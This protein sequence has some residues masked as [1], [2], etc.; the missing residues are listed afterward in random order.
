[1]TSP[2]QH[3][4]RENSV[5]VG[6]SSI[7]EAPRRKNIRVSYTGKEEDDEDKSEDTPWTNFRQLRS[8]REEK[9]YSMIT[10]SRSNRIMKRRRILPK[11]TTEPDVRVNVV[12]KKLR[13]RQSPKEQH[14][15]SNSPHLASRHRLSLNRNNTGSNA[16]GKKKELR[17]TKSSSDNELNILTLDDGS[18][19]TVSSLPLAM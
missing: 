13:V 18:F 15:P 16:C 6:I 10:P 4:G 5:K 1:M 3:R 14:V 11:N 2:L 8:Q 7:D 17:N 9:G 19:P 12:I